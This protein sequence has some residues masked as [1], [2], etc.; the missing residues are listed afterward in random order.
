[1]SNFRAPVILASLGF[2]LYGCGGSSSVSSGS[3]NEI[4]GVPLSQYQAI[5]PDGS[6]MEIEILANDNLAWSGE[7]AVAAETGP[8]AHQ[9]GSFEGK[10]SGTTVSATC[11]AIGGT[12]FELTGTVNSASTMQLTRS[13]IP[14]TVLNFTLVKPQNPKARAD[15]SF[16][17]NTNGS[18][19]RVT[20][21]T[22][23]FSVQGG[24]TM[25]EYRGTWL[26][27]N[28][29]FW[30]YSSGFATIVTYI[31]DFA[32][33]TANFANY[34]LSDFGTASQTSSSGQVS[35]YSGVTK[36]QFKYRTTTQV[37]P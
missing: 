19:G 14:G 12:E 25:T 1:M 17:M 27:L 31:N 35:V 2:C 8:Y 36:S 22:N 6:P 28:V 16:N 11:E 9:V 34:K 24:G 13:D 5:L 23:P 26:G 20:M 37:S 29:T 15:T 7:F 32:I 3:G 10:V 30:A 18:N 4:G 33:S 21:S